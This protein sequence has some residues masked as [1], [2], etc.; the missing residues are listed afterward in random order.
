MAH[1]RVEQQASNPETSSVDAK[2]ALCIKESNLQG[3]MFGVL[4]DFGFVIEGSTCER[5]AAAQRSYWEAYL[6]LGPEPQTKQDAARAATSPN[7]DPHE[8]P[9]SA[10]STGIAKPLKPRAFNDATPLGPCHA[11][12]ER[13]QVADDSA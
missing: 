8:N 1:I 4:S 10:P 2:W 6:P 11:T 9:R 5:Q 3:R 7:P 13:R 12:A